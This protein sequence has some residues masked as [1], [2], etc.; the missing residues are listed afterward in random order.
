MSWDILFNVFTLENIL[1]MNI[2]LFLGVIFGSLPGLTT[3]LAVVLFT[4]ITFGMEPLPAMLLLL[5]LYC[6]GTYGGSITAIL[7][8]TPGTPAATATSIDGYPLAQKGMAKKALHMAI[9]ASAVAGLISGIVLMVAAPQIA[10]ITL[11]FG[12]PE[13]F[14]LA[15]FGLSIITSVSSEDMLGGAIAGCIGLLLSTVGIDLFSGMTRFTFGTL[16]LTGGINTLI[17]MIGAFAITE[18]MIKAS[19]I[20]KHSKE[21]VKVVEKIKIGSTKGLTV[22]DIKKSIGTIIRSAF[23]GIGVGAMPGTGAAIASFVSYDV[24]KRSSKHPE[25]YGKGELNGVAATESGNNGVTGAT[26]IP[27]FT[28]GIPGDAVTAVLL[29]AL[30]IHGLQP[31]PNLFSASGG[32]VYAIFIGFIVINL[33]MFLQ[34]S[35]LLKWFAKIANISD[36]LLIPLIILF[37]AAG[38]YSV[39]SSSFDLLLIAIFGLVAFVLKKMNISILPMVLG[40]VLGQIA[41]TN[42]RRSMS[43]SLGGVPVFFTRPICISFLALTVISVA[44]AFYKKYKKRRKIAEQADIA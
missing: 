11:L 26:M 43:M 2:G 18:I 36:T 24:A 33:F 32:V 30:M 17:I 3:V 34:G 6:G 31:G 21:G 22:K 38:A 5:G 41:E 37:C 20:I 44:T 16:S 40:A 25:A 42:F 15:V 28:L 4:P 8:N 29:G 23:I 35:L 27:L 39:N 9:F 13:Y 12:S 19:G 7:I 14:T 10:K 1:F